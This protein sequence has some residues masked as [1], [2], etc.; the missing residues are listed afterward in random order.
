MRMEALPSP[1]SSQPKWGDLKFTQPA[2]DANR[3]ATLSF[4]IPSAVE[5]SAVLSPRS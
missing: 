4:V 3:G 1:L 5:G 2:S